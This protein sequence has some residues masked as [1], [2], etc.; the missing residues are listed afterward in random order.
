MYPQHIPNVQCHAPGIYSS[1]I[2]GMGLSKASTIAIKNN[3][4]KRTN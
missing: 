3:Y 2:Y 1:N 4:N